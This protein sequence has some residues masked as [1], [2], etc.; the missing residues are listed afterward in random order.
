M[1][2]YMQGLSINSFDLNGT[3]YPLIWG[4]DAVNYTIGS[5]PEISSY[6]FA[7][8]MNSDIVKGKIVLCQSFRGSTGI[9]L[10][11]GVGTIMSSAFYTDFA[12][13]Y[14]LPATVISPEDAL[15]VLDYIRTTE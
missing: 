2:L 11:D 15:T 10:A 7:D 6:C 8:A 14:P 1:H 12:F 5:N 3:I 13:S 9:L 4:G